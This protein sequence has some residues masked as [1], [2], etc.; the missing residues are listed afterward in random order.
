MNT[1]VKEQ[2][3][4][5]VQL[6]SFRLGDEEFV[7]DILKVQ[8]IN[9]MVEITKLPEAPHYYEGVIN[10]RGKV[11]PVLNLR[12]RFDMESK[13][14]DK[15]TR[16]IVCDIEG[17]PVGMVV[18]EVDE[19]LRLHRSTIDPAP[20]I[21]TSCNT[22]YITGVAKLDERLLIFLNVSRIAS[23]A[24]SV[25]ESETEGSE[26]Q[27]NMKTENSTSTSDIVDSGVGLEG[28]PVMNSIE[29]IVTKLKDV[30][31][32][33]NENTNELV[34]AANE[35]VSCAQA[36][37]KAAEHMSEL[38]GKQAQRAGQVSTTVEETTVAFTDAWRISGDSTRKLAEMIKTIQSETESAKQSMEAG[39]QVVYK[40]REMADKASSSLNEAVNMSKEAM[41]VIEQIAPPSGQAAGKKK[42]V[43][44]TVT[45]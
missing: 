3:D 10:L 42:R 23:E 27:L 29:M 14:W 30:T 18:D 28:S 32:E 37:V 39:I 4:E 40:G 6:A 1:H 31:R 43:K 24:P 41:G 20:D 36:T 16:I 7:V 34:S 26:P 21:I 12:K 9:R 19:V 44:Q 17:H 33:L 8:E 5:I 38:T 13:E 45:V 25:M 15:N 35:V 11:I 2:L 22:D